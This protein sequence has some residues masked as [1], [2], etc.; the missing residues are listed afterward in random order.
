MNVEAHPLSASRLVAAWDAPAEETGSLRFL[1]RLGGKP[2]AI[3]DG[4][5]VF[6]GGLDAATRYVLTVETV[7]AGGNVS[8]PSNGVS[9]TTRPEDRGP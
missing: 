8:A 1:I 7:D 3:T 9:V 4:T 5:A 2:W 6:L